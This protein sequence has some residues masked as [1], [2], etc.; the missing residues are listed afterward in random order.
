MVDYAGFH[1][2]SWID[3][4][5]LFEATEFA[6]DTVVLRLDLLVLARLYLDVESLAIKFSS[7]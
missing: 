1:G 5:V 6:F 3:A 4:T 2:F 7:K